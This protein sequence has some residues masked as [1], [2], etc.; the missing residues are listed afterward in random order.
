MLSNRDDIVLEKYKV[1]LNNNETV[2]H[3]K[4]VEAI[5][6]NGVCMKILQVLVLIFGL[7]VFAKAQKVV[8]SGT[9]ADETGAVI[10]NTKVIATNSER[11]TYQAVTNADGIFHLEIPSGVYSIDFE[12]TGF[13]VYKIE[14]YKVAP[15][16]KGRMNLDIVLEVRNCNDPLVDC[17]DVT[18]EPL[19]NEKQL[20]K[21]IKKKGK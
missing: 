14:K 3:L 18:T 10:S 9:L 16:A 5:I 13:K 2:A 21:L 8:L 17:H 7:S 19:K 15:I 11:K 20:N 4:R 6:S 1:V 12:A